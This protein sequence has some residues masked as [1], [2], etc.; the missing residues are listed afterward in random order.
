MPEPILDLTDVK[1]H[2]P[3]HRGFMV[4]TLV[5]TVATKTTDNVVAGSGGSASLCVIKTDGFLYCWGFNTNGQVGNGT[6][7]HS[8]EA[9]LA[10][11]W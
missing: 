6:S 9:K 1:T 4:K 5:G 7:P 10:L 3:V 11:T 2:F 8:S